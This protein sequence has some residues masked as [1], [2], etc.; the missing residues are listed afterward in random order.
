MSFPFY[1]KASLI[2]L[3]LF[4]F[5]SMLSIGQQILVP[6]IFS[7]LAAILLSPLVAFLVRERFKR[8]LAIALVLILVFGIVILLTV[9]LSNQIVRFG[10]ALP[11]LIGNFNLLVNEAINWISYQFNISVTD[12]RLWI[13]D[14][15]SEM[16]TGASSEVGETLIST[17]ASLM[18]VILIP[19]YM[20]LLLFYQPLL[21]EFIH[22][23]FSADKQKDVNDVISKTKKIIQSYLIGLMTEAFIVAILYSI[24]LLALGIQYA[25]LLAIIGALLNLI[26]YLGA[27]IAAS[28]PMIV[29]LATESPIYALLVL[30]AYIFIQFIDNN[31][32][33]PRVVASKVRINAL[34][35]IIVVIAGGALW[36]ISGM[37]LSIPLTAIL[38]VVFDHIDGLKPW[39]YVLGNSVPVSPHAAKPKKKVM[40][41][42]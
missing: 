19:V 10:N 26:P 29:A 39:G 12:L 14:R 36:G 28:L 7:T 18:F 17:G 40:A 34:V 1:V 3:G 13:D 27:I 33:I 8:G 6:L 22:R 37:F 11:E 41:K 23:L 2:C 5:I 16:L 42:S 24:A 32:I 21:I 4:A 25:V 30:A 20:F 38:K 15:S 31:I 9:L 35:S